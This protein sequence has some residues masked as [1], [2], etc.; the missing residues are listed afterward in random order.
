MVS[1]F[2]SYV[3][4]LLFL[5]NNPEKVCLRGM[6]LKKEDK[7]QEE[8]DLPMKIPMS[9]PVLVMQSRGKK[10]CGMSYTRH[11]S[12]SCGKGEV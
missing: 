1:A 11:G 9:F 7:Y 10:V 4:G 8:K 3:F 5:P 2:L 6:R 12:V